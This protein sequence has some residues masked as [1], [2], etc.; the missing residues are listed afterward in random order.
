M[1][2]M[3]ITIDE[4]VFDVLEDVSEK[5]GIRKSKLIEMAL[6]AEKSL[7]DI[8]IEHI[9]KEVKEQDEWHSWEEVKKELNL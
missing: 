4:K 9:I 5:T 8:E 2:K 3:S 6:T 7:E 1:P